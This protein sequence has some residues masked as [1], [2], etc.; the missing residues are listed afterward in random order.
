MILP[1][2]CLRA[3]IK[4]DRGLQKC[5]SLFAYSPTC[6]PEEDW[7]NM[8]GVIVDK[9]TLGLMKQYGYQYHEKGQMIVGVLIQDVDQEVLKIMS[10]KMQSLMQET[11]TE[12]IEDTKETK[13]K[14]EDTKTDETEADD[15]EDLVK[16]MEKLET[17]D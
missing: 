4:T 7:R 9:Y 8:D 10:S 11:E 17:E 12:A 6:L 16:L 14:T 15:T 5:V 1:N 13:T 3:R 2:L